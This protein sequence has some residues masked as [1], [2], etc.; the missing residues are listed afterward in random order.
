[1]AARSAA[2]SPASAVR[3]RY[4]RRPSSTPLPVCRQRS[5]LPATWANGVLCLPLN[6]TAGVQPL[7]EH[8]LADLA[9]VEAVGLQRIAPL[10]ERELIQLGRRQRAIF[11]AG[12]AL[13]GRFSGF[14]SGGRVGFGNHGLG[15]P[16]RIGSDGRRRL[17]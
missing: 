13:R 9:L 4:A 12:A 11:E 6:A 8:Q 2:A 10:V 17:T 7:Q 3:T 1:M 15:P 5:R 14:G 16:S